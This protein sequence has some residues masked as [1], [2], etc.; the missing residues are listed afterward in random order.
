MD[1]TP[2]MQPPASKRD[3]CM[4]TSRAG[5]ISHS[6]TPDVCAHRDQQAGSKPAAAAAVAGAAGAAGAGGLTLAPLLVLAAAAGRQS[7]IPDSP[8]AETIFGGN[9]GWSTSGYMS[10]TGG[11]LFLSPLNACG[12]NQ[13][14]C[15][16][17]CWHTVW[18]VTCVD[19]DSC[20]F[21]YM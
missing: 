15:H 1:A 14:C 4:D 21:L 12:R 18:V 7:D 11:G 9:G 2:D 5:V 16:S 19:C 6:H 10:R 3:S 8:L 20:G 17:I 13:K